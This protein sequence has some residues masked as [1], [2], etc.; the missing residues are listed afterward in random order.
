[1][2]RIIAIAVLCLSLS[3][4]QAVTRSFGGTT[5]IKLTE[6]ETLINAT[7]KESNLWVLTRDKDG[8][9]QFREYSVLGVLQ[10]KVV[11]E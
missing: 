3:G 5:T 1:M 6:G 7:W 8:K 11:F 9:A 10:G 2:K 4:C